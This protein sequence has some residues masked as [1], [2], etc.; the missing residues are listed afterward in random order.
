MVHHFLHHGHNRSILPFSDMFKSISHCLKNRV[1]STLFH[2]VSPFL[3][4]NQAT[5]LYLLCFTLYCFTVL[6]VNQAT[7]LCS[8]Q[9][10]S[11][12]AGPAPSFFFHQ[13]MQVT[14]TLRAKQAGGADGSAMVRGMTP[15]TVAK[16]WCPQVGVSLVMGVPLVIIHFC[17]GF[18]YRLVSTIQLLGYPDFRTPP[19]EIMPEVSNNPM[20]PLLSES[21]A[22]KSCATGP[23]STLG[24]HAWYLGEKKDT[25]ISRV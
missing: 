25:T 19:C 16:N 20:T 23:W 11:V 8:A 1:E 12:P 18:S 15:K 7:Y 10:F 22:P 3:M 2:I 14:L 5:Y 9:V 6:M 4:L 24:S 13:T 21:P 17:L